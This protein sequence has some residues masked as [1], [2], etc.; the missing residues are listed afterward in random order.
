MFSSDA[1]ETDSQ[2]C[3]ELI[4]KLSFLSN[5]DKSEINRELESICER[6]EYLITKWQL[7]PKNIESHLNTFLSL[8]IDII[9]KSEINS[10]KFNASFRLITRL[11]TSIGYKSVCRHFPTQVFWLTKLINWSEL[12]NINQS[13]SWQTRFALLLWLSMAV[14]T[15]FHLSKFDANSGDN[16]NENTITKRYSID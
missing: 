3:I 15:P 7:S 9:T 4:K 14:K 8:I 11:I 2:L 1:F 10:N 5:E 12:Q 6:F 16:K 13:N